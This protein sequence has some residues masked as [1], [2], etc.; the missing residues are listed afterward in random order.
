MGHDR[1][2]EALSE[3][4]DQSLMAEVNHYRR[5]EHKRKAFQESITRLEDQIF[6]TDVEHRMCISRLE[7]ARVLVHI[8]GEMCH[9]HIVL[10]SFLS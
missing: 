1:M 6:T 5:L 7:A 8:Q 4:G 2:D 9:G 3:I 10:F